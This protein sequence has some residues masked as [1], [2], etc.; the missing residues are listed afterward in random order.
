MKK[1][2]MNLKRIKSQELKEDLE[3]I[4]KY[5]KSERNKTIPIEKVIHK[6]HIKKR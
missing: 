5:E 4:K 6:L 2:N 1:K 3:A